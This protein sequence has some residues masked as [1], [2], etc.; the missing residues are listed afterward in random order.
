VF[1]EVLKERDLQIEM[2]KH[3]EQMRQTREN[4]ELQRYQEAQNEI[5]KA[6]QEKLE[7]RAK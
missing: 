5:A 1:T 6:E 7:R 3:I 2:K 4:D